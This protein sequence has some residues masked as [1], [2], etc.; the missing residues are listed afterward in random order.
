MF[1]LYYIIYKNYT[2]SKLLYVSVL[3]MYKLHVTCTYLFSCKLHCKVTCESINN[4]SKIVWK[5]VVRSTR[6]WIC[7]RGLVI[8]VV[9]LR[10][11]ARGWLETASWPSVRAQVKYG[12]HVVIWTACKI[13]HKQYKTS[14]GFQAHPREC[15]YASGSISI[16]PDYQYQSLDEHVRVSE[17]FIFHRHLSPV[18]QTYDHN[19]SSIC[20]HIP[21]ISE[22]CTYIKW[23]IINDFT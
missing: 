14:C 3:I 6:I 10:P 11:R 19:I 16:W 9:D 12:T 18:E 8:R 23:I 7:S 2:I 4:Y 21:H 20:H 15:L 22:L 5:C 17:I 13:T 1:L